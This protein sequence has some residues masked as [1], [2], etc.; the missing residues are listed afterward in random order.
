MI[1]KDS[2][3]GDIHIELNKDV[4]ILH[5][6]NLVI[7]MNSDEKTHGSGRVFIRIK[8]EKDLNVLMEA[9]RKSRIYIKREEIIKKKEQYLS[10]SGQTRFE[11]LKPQ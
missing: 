9:I 6:E 2:S 11:V 3:T 10:F 1:G 4:E 7:F 5:T 8:N